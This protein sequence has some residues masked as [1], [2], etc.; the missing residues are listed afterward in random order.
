MTT[1]II[2]DLDDELQSTLRN[3]AARHGHSMEEK[4]RGILR[5]ALAQPQPPTPLGQRLVQRFRGV[6]MDL[7]LPARSLPRMPPHWDDPA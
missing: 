2:P 5:Q 4:A 1:L 6:A 7:P 3:L